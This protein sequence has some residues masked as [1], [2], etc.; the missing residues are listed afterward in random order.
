MKVTVP[1]FL[2]IVAARAIATTESKAAETIYRS[3]ISNEQLRR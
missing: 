3:G 1:L 2:L